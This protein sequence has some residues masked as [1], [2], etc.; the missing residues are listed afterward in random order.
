MKVYFHH[1]LIHLSGAKGKVKEDSFFSTFAF[2]SQ[3]LGDE[4][5]LSSP[6]YSICCNLT[7]LIVSP[8][9]DTVV[10]VA[11]YPG[12]SSSKL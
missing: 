11:E 9:I 4:G 10:E 2:A 8:E 3:K 6:T 12:A 5:L 7:F 1:L